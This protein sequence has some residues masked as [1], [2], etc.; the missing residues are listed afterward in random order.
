M[1]SFPEAKL[2]L[3]CNHYLE[4]SPQGASDRKI[5]ICLVNSAFNLSQRS[6]RSYGGQRA[7]AGFTDRVAGSSAAGSR[8]RQSLQRPQP[9]SARYGLAQS[10]GVV[11]GSD[12]SR[13]ELQ[14]AVA[15]TSK[16]CRTS[17]A[18]ETISS[19]RNE[20]DRTQTKAQQKSTALVDVPSLIA[21]W[22]QVRVP[23]GPPRFT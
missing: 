13:H 17:F 1:N 10:I 5:P 23:P 18:P 15:I 7:S 11:G 20:H 9:L 19:K 4:P 6:A 2:M 12:K 21:V 3:R 14:L 8:A 22:L 16:D